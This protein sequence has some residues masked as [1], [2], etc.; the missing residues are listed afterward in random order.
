MKGMTRLAALLLAV[1]ILASGVHV[2]AGDLWSEEY[3]RAYDV[4]GGLSDAEI[5][6][7]DALC[8]EFMSEHQIDLALLALPTEQYT[9]RTLSEYARGYYESCGFGYGPDK[10]GIQM[11]WDTNTDEM[12]LETFGAAGDLIP[13]SYLEFVAESAPAYRENYGIFG[14]MY[15]VTKYLSD[16]MADPKRFAAPASS[17]EETETAP[18]SGDGVL[19]VGEG[20][21]LPAW[22]PVDPEHFENYHDYDA[23]RVVDD[24]HLLT[25]EEI[26][27]LT[28]QAAE[29]SEKYGM[30]VVVYTARHPGSLDPQEFSDRYYLLHGY[31]LGDNYDGIAL[32][33]FKRPGYVGSV[34]IT[35][36]GTGA[37]K[38]TAVAESRLRSRCVG[39]MGDDTNYDAISG[40]LS[41]TEHLLRT[42]R[43]PRSLGSWIF[44]TIL[45]LLIGAV[46]GVVALFRAR[47]KMV[48]P[49]IRENADAY[50]I[51]GSLHVT[52][53]GDEYLETT[54]S[55]IYDPVK[56]TRSNDSDSSSSSGRSSYS[57]SYSGS[58]GNIH[59]GSGRN[60]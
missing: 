39:K 53:M 9:G 16:Y 2:F 19:R 49:S 3:Y 26:R 21:D 60:F 18:A 15:G 51:P 38:L 43:A 37:K 54:I 55:Q 8:L 24:A 56:E 17:Q 28:Q 50:L 1:L 31:G 6:E 36:S 10:D 59:S 45:E 58:S 48:S 46:V 14:P 4:S 7:L 25:E 40:W 35:A 20:G 12:V 27:A 22:Y 52:N 23:P 5:D 42:G 41:Q 29:I 13:A 30:D 44:M 33:V 32:T 57:S 34:C 11:V 47:S